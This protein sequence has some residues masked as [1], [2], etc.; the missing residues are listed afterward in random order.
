METY[1]EL[2]PSE[3]LV[4]YYEGVNLMNL[5]APDLYREARI[6]TRKYE[7]RIS[8]DWLEDVKQMAILLLLERME[9]YPKEKGSSRVLRVRK[10]L[11]YWYNKHKGTVVT[12]N[13]V[14]DMTIHYDD[15]E[16]EE[17]APAEIMDALAVMD[18]GISMFINQL[19]EGADLSVRERDVV[20]L[21]S[22]GYTIKETQDH[23]GLSQKAVRYAFDTAI[24][25][26][27]ES[28]KDQEDPTE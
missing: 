16:D 8:E 19:I 22:K 12:P 15:D 17:M 7:G 3:Y 28:A 27:K 18:N 1:I 24:D 13:E 23:L 4:L 25:K 20:E 11:N 21:I 5:K 2:T 14:E 9:D 26:L 10:Q 6:L